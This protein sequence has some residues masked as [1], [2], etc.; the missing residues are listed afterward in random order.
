MLKKGVYLEALQWRSLTHD[1]VLPLRG[2]F[3]E[4]SYSFLVSP[5]TIHGTITEWRKN[6]K[7]DVKE[8]QRLVGFRCLSEQVDLIDSNLL[9]VRGSQRYSVYSRGRNYSW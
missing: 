7:P 8:I 4:N 5:F 6:Q 1:F 3:E 2:I 9:D